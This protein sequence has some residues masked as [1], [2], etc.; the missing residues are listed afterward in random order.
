MSVSS[1]CTSGSDALGIAHAMIESGVAD[2]VL[3]GG[4]EAPICPLLFAAFDRLTMMPTCF[5]ATAATASRP[6]SA[7][8]AG[9]VL[10]EGSAVFVLESAKREVLIA[11]AYFVAT[12]ATRMAIT[13][14]ARRC[15]HVVVLTNGVETSDTPGMSLLGRAHYAELFAANADA[16]RCPNADAGVEIWEWQGKA[17]GDPRQTQGLLHAKFAVVDGEVALVGSFN[18][19]PRSEHLNSESA[20]VFENPALAAQLARTFRDRDLLTSRRIEPAEA[21][22]FERPAQVFQ[23]FRQEFAGLFEDQL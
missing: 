7:D 19:D 11:N 10:G 13:A 3:A 6:F 5:N 23:R 20:I 21:A 1:A 16:K 12:P 15:V 17:A 14:A 2:L 18:L 8:R 22:T 4:A 9:F